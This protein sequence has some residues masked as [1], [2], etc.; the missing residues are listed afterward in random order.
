MKVNTRRE[1]IAKAASIAL[2]PPAAN[3]DSRSDSFIGTQQWAGDRPGNGTAGF[4]RSMTGPLDVAAA[5]GDVT[6]VR[7]GTNRLAAPAAAT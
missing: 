4:G 5:A 2:H 7:T 6:V 3:R 1:E